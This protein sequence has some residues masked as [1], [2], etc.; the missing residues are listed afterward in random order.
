MSQ[1]AKPTLNIITSSSSGS[2]FSL[3]PLTADTALGRFAKKISPS[4]SPSSAK[5]DREKFLNR[6]DRF[7]NLVLSKSTSAINVTNHNT[8]IPEKI[9][10]LS[11]SDQ[12]WIKSGIKDIDLLLL[13]AVFTELVIRGRIAT[14]ELKRKALNILATQRYGLDVVS[15]DPTGNDLYDDV[16]FALNEK[17]KQN[18]SSRI[19]TYIKGI[20]DTF[21]KT[22]VTRIVQ[23]LV[24]ARMLRTNRGVDLMVVNLE[25]YPMVDR[26]IKDR[27]RKEICDVLTTI[28]DRYH[29]TSISPSTPVTGLSPALYALASLLYLHDDLMHRE[30]IVKHFATNTNAVKQLKHTTREMIAQYEQWQQQRGFQ[31]DSA[32]YQQLF[33]VVTEFGHKK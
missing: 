3:S 1:R 7:T 11:L 18:N 24:N 10:L 26:T 6:I 32:I 19:V 13:W 17:Y 30:V 22:I 25:V 8:T 9:L 29:V 12:G 16:L 2:S 4:S 21:S 31:R 27:I 5:E 15:L 28:E 14:Y 33:H 23:P 20:R